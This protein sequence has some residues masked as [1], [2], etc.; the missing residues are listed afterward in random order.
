MNQFKEHVFG[1]CL[2]SEGNALAPSCGCSEVFTRYV[3]RY[4][5]TI[6]CGFAALCISY[7][8]RDLIGHDYLYLATRQAVSPLFWNMLFVIGAIL[9]CT[10]SLIS[11]VRGE[12]VSYYFLNAA[13]RIFNMAAEVGAL[14]FGVLVAM[15][16]VALSGGTI[17]AW[18]MLGHSILASVLLGYSLFLN[19]LVWWFVLYTEDDKY[20][21]P[22]LIYIESKPLLKLGVA[23]LSL[24]V[25]IC[26]VIGT[27]PH[28][29]KP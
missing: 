16:V 3:S 13:K 23:A 22:Y 10:S 4:W 26:L 21:P 27:E 5:V 6:A 18:G 11:I 8:S 20:K 17:S 9:I 14:T 24:V 28:P 15:V 25:L 29:P 19:I 12:V 2:D 1:P 7:Y